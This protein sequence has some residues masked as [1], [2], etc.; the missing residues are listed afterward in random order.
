MT[1]SAGW[2]LSNR[3]HQQWSDHLKQTMPSPKM[4]GIPMKTLRSPNLMISLLLSRLQRSHMMTNTSKDIFNIRLLTAVNIVKLCQNQHHQQEDLSFIIGHKQT[5]YLHVL[6][7]QSHLLCNPK[8]FK[9][10]SI[11]LN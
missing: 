3:A 11:K 6:I 5:H 9:F 2:R 8:T 1:V 4:I 7:I 10:V